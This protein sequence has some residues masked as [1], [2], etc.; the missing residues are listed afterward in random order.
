[1]RLKF[2]GALNCL[3]WRCFS[4]VADFRCMSRNEAILVVGEWL[5]HA[6]SSRSVSGIVHSYPLHP[7]DVLEAK[8]I[9]TSKWKKQI[10]RRDQSSG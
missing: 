5:K 7:A 8:S 6:P 4:F 9:A 3:V 1:M 10:G 2:E